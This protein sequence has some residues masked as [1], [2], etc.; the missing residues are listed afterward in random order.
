MRKVEKDLSVVPESLNSTANLKRNSVITQKKYPKKKKK[1]DEQYKKDDTK[2]FLIKI[3]HNKCAYCEQKLLQVIPQNVRLP[4]ETSTIDHYRPKNKYYWLAFSWDNLLLCCYG[5]GDT[6]RSK[7]DILNSAVV[8]SKSFDLKIH[9]S[10]K[11]YNRLERPKMVHPEL[12]DV[13]D[14]L[15]FDTKGNIS[16]HDERVQYTIDCCGLDRDYLNIERKKLFD[17][18]KR[19]LE[20]AKAQ[21]NQALFQSTVL[22]FKDDNENMDNEFIAFRIWVLNWIVKN[23]L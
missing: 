4:D 11:L 21:N 10:T 7:F 6:K 20:D 17:D 14:K 19:K 16:S 3:Y 9:C 1:V 18:F 23:F 8:Y 13:M 2:K 5:C 22:K 12:E 15:I